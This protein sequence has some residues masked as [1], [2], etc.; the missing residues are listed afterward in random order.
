MFALLRDFGKEE[1][2]DD[3]FRERYPDL[4]PTLS[5]LDLSPENRLLVPSGTYERGFRIARTLDDLK[6]EALQLWEQ[7]KYPMHAPSLSSVDARLRCTEMV[8]ALR[9]EVDAL[10]EGLERAYQRTYE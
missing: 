8:G 6:Q 10:R 1:F 4:I 9:K 3:T 5:K 2:E 7:T